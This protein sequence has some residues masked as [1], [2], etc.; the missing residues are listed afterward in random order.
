MIAGS[1]E[2]Y[3]EAN[4]LDIPAQWQRFEPHIGK[5]PGQVG[6]ATYGLLFPNEKGDGW[7][8]VCGVEVSDFQGVPA[9][10]KHFPI[11][12]TKYAVFTHHGYLATLRDSMNYIWNKWLPESKTRITR[13]ARVEK[14]SANFRP[15]APG[16][17]EIWIP[18][19]P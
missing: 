1:S 12:K 5:M 6:R 3:T 2:F 14:Y 11:G 10:F 15:D 16:G 13:G 19:A 9:E 8:Y 17:V 4:M 18:L 7:E